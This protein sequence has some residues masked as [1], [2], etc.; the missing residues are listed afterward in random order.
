MNVLI[1]PSANQFSGPFVNVQDGFHI[2]ASRDKA[3]II[4]FYERPAGV[5]WFEDFDMMFCQEQHAADTIKVIRLATDDEVKLFRIPLWIQG[6]EVPTCCGQ[7][8]HFVG[9]LNDDRICTERP[10]D[11]KM[12]WHDAASFYVFTC[13]QCLG[14]KAVGQQF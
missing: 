11:A 3:V 2:L 10:P 12:W 8:M 13:S 6:D 1:P 7:P 4:E 5:D 14:C 9:Q